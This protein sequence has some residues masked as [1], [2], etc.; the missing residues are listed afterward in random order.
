MKKCAICGCDAIEPGFAVIP[1]VR[2][3]VTI[4]F[5]DVPALICGPCG[6][7]YFDEKTTSNLLETADKASF[8][9]VEVSV[10]RYVA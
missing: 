8:E 7:Q 2:D 5:R 3:N 9:G 4:V 6:E 1:F 10:L